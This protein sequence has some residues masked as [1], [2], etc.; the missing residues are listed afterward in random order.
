[1]EKPRKGRFSCL[2]PFLQR[3]LASDEVKHKTPCKLL[4]A[5]DVKT[6][7]LPH[8]HSSPNQ[9]QLQSLR[10][11]DTAALQ[12]FT[13]WRAHYSKY[14]SLSSF[15]FSAAKPESLHAVINTDSVYDSHCASLI[16]LVYRC[17]RMANIINQYI[18][19]IRK[20]LILAHY[21]LAQ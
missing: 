19:V 2:I 9:V 13:A 1:M 6:L 11:V 21:F 4:G 3:V 12:F 16:L 15:Q 7:P 20:P 17:T 14:Y 5:K 8:P 18:T 10:I